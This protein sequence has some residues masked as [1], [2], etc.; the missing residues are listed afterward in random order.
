[1]VSHSFPT[2][3]S[4]DLLFA[5]VQLRPATGTA[6]ASIRIEGLDPSATY[7]VV[8]EQPAGEAMF[9]SQK[10]PGWLTGAVLTGEALSRIGLRPP[11]LAP[12]NAILIAIENTEI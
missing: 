4:S 5:F 11:I 12:E 7:R 1:L 3:R 9:M 8:A 6:P 10:S 2:R